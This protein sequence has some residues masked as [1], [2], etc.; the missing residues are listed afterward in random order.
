MIY[1]LGR[2]PRN[3]ERNPVPVHTRGKWEFQIFHRHPARLV[4]SGEASP[5]ETGD[6]FFIFRPDCAHGWRGG[7][8]PQCSISSF[9]LHPVP[10]TLRSLMQSSPYLSVQINADG[11]AVV[12]DIAARVSDEL[13]RP[14]PLTPLRFEKYGSELSL[15]F[16]EAFGGPLPDANQESRIVEIA[17][18]WY[19]NNLDRGVG[20]KEAAAE[21]GYSESHLRRLFVAAQNESPREVFLRI[22]MEKARSLLRNNR[23]PILNIALACGYPNHSSF[24]RAF[25]R[26]FGIAPVDS[27]SK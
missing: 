15:L 11:L 4:L 17:K 20:V 23:L 3:Y 24:S 27:V 18:S 2:G 21:M 13:K 16:L 5:P 26:Y 8:E 25:K 7:R 9:H 19:E 14:G 22:R 12:A 6:N 10:E 1:Y